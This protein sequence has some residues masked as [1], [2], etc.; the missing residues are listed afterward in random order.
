MPS[1]VGGEPG[2]GAA[3]VCGVEHAVVGL[4]RVAAAQAA[5]VGAR[6]N[7]VLPGMIDTPGLR[8]QVPADGGQDP[9]GA[10]ARIPAGRPG[11]PDEL[12]AA[13]V[14]LA[15]PEVAYVTGIALPVDGGFLAVAV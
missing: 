6:V 12:A 14:W 7:A 3:D 4:T 13:A 8:A 15:G 2:D 10:V 9:L 5:R 11:S 1:L